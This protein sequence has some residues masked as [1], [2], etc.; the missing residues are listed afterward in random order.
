MKNCENCFYFCK[1]TASKRLTD[2]H[3]SEGGNCPYYWPEEEFLTKMS[4]D[5]M[6]GINL[7]RWD[8]LT[9]HNLEVERR[10]KPRLV[11]IYGL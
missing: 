1:G 5:R 6:Q 3:I 2:M 7:S 10:F 8:Y 11:G 4:L 9:M